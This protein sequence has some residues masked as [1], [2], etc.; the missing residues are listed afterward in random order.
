MYLLSFT[1]IEFLLGVD[2]IRNVSGIQTGALDPAKGMFW[3][4]NSGYIMAKLEGE[5][6]LA[7]AAGNRFTYHIGGFRFGI[8]T[9]RKISLNIAN[10]QNNEIHINADI[11]QWFKSKSEIRIAETNNCQTPGT[12]AVKFADNYANMF[13]IR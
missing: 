10:N 1:K 13:T 8:N 12:L 4:W 11:N 7:N 9:V 6:P 2:S 5:S 3:T